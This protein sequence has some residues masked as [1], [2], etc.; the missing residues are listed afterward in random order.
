[1]FDDCLTHIPLLNTTRYPKD[2]ALFFK[3]L[4]KEIGLK[5]VSAETAEARDDTIDSLERAKKSLSFLKNTA[6]EAINK[7]ADYADAKLVPAVTKCDALEL[8]ATAAAEAFEVT[9]S[10]CDAGACSVLALAGT[11]PACWPCRIK[12]SIA[13]KVKM[14]IVAN[15]AACKVGLNFF[16][17]VA[18]LIKAGL[19][20]FHYSIKVA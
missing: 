9:R 19:W 3:K 12:Q 16:E 17:G 4:P 7:Y 6:M 2:K 13:E 18:V 1:M 10:V 11:N 5:S 20:G 8:K 14:S 15:F